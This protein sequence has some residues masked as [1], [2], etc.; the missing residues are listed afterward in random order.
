MAEAA[1]PT[2][3]APRGFGVNRDDGRVRLPGSL[4]ANRRIAQWLAF[5][6]PGVVKVQIGKAELGQGIL[7]ALQLV[8]AEE[9]DVP[10][11]AVRMLS[12]STARGPDEGMTSGSLSVQD[13]GGALRQ[14]CAEVRALALRAAAD[15]SGVPIERIARARRPPAQR[16]R[17][18]PRRLLVAARRHRPRHRVHRRA[19][20]QAARRTPPVRPRTAG[21]HR[22]RRQGVRPRA[23]HPRPAAAAACCTAA[24]CVAPR[25]APSW[26]TGRRPRSARCAKACAAGPTAASSRWWRR[27]SARP[28][29]WP[30]VCAS[31]CSGRWPSALPDANDLAAWLGAAPSET[32][33]PAQ[34]GEAPW[35]AE[36]DDGQGLG[37]RR[38]EAEYFKPYLA[39]A[40]IGT[41]C[42][43]AKWD[44]TTLEVWT[45][46]QGI[47]NLRD[48][49]VLALAGE[50]NP[51]AKDAITIHHVEGSGCYG[52]NGAEDASLDAVLLARAVPGRP[53]LLKWSREDELRLGAIRPGDGGEDACRPRHGGQSRRL[54]PRRVGDDAQLARVS[55]RKAHDAPP[56]LVPRSAGTATAARTFLLPQAAAPNATRYRVRAP[57]GSSSTS[58]RRCPCA[59]RPCARSAH[60]PTCSRSSRSWTS[61]ARQ[62]A[63]TRSSSASR[64]SMTTVRAQCSRPRRSARA[65]AVA[66]TS[67]AAGWDRVRALQEHRRLRRGDRR[68]HRERRNG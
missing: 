50:A 53:V 20:A 66:P 46:S 19:A 57:A 62:P 10:I 26:S 9:L 49:L 40:S 36:Q 13:S 39:H 44:G 35:P 56:G 45:H 60:T 25:W 31:A 17:A 24:C 43:I 48:D 52:H 37:A 61:S 4:H 63:A 23:L 65:G 30:I 6:E 15:V 28:T 21:A 55:T 27:A 51:P 68:A 16:R 59:R 34:R 32:T 41:S 7:T 22:S 14:A 67:S 58:S 1:K 2:P 3:S 38:F 47:H 42:A 12:A 33:V 29:R 11:E 54:E 5:D 18:E 64:T 8:V